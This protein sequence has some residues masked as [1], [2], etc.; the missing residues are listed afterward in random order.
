MGAPSGS[1]A[2]VNALKDRLMNKTPVEP[3]APRPAGS[4]AR[5][6]EMSKLNK[7]QTAPRQQPAPKPPPAT[8]RPVPA[9]L[10][11]IEPPPSGLASNEGDT[12]QPTDNTEMTQAAPEAT[13]EPLSPQLIALARKERLVLKAQQELNKSKEAWKQEQANSISLDRLKSE[14]LKVLSE[15]GITPEKLVEL[16]INQTAEQDPQQDLKNEIAA[17]KQQLQDFID[18]ENG[19]LAQ[20]DRQEYDQV[21]S[22]ISRDVEL[23]VDSD[24][25]Y[26]TIKSEGATKDVVELI[27]S[28]FDEEGIVLDVEEAARLVEEKLV[29]Q[30]YSKYEKYSKYD[31]IKARAGK[32]SETAEATTEQS[33]QADINKP[34]INTLTN[35][36]VSTKPLSARDKAVLKVQE[37]LNS[38]KGR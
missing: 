38:L 25:A 7:F 22:Q 19:K 29:E 36:G 12:V 18:P 14:T 6:E 32:L 26:G 13:G 35:M 11:D 20:R 5:R 16:Q 21:I 8:A 17:L 2:R 1:T 28:V 10:E 37:R 4:S 15:V 23:T 3:V 30:V 33:L 27:E 9:N 31:K 34:K 24:P